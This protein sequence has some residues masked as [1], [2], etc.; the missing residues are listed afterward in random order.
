MDGGRGTAGT[1]TG[2]ADGA[3]T[4][5]AKVSASIVDI[6]SVSGGSPHKAYRESAFFGL[7]IAKVYCLSPTDTVIVVSG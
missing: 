5:F 2:F 3:T 6:V 1:D 7:P 4:S